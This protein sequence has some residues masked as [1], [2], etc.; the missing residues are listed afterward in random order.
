MLLAKARSEESLRTAAMSTIQVFKTL[1]RWRKRNP[2]EN[3]QE[4]N[5]LAPKLIMCMP[6]PFVLPTTF[7]MYSDI[8]QN[9]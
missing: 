6:T 4:R 5:L 7:S 1:R 9:G 2:L 8:S 3:L